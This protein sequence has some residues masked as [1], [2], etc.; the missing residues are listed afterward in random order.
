VVE[1]AQCIHEENFA[2]NPMNLRN[3]QLFVT[4]LNK[5]VCWGAGGDSPVLVAMMLGPLPA[6]AVQSLAV[7]VCGLWCGCMDSACRSVSDFI[8]L[9]EEGPST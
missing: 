7:R 5:L 9:Q 6:S 8:Q 3:V 2:V 1:N 4:V